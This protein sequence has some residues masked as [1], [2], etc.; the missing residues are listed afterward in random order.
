[1]IIF[2]V[3]FTFI[4]TKCILRVVMYVN[5]CLIIIDSILIFK[6]KSH[7]LFSTHQVKLIICETK[8]KSNDSCIRI[9]I[10]MTFV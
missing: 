4:I 7:T 10:V 8:F 1:M 6:S 3:I 9:I 5:F 2:N